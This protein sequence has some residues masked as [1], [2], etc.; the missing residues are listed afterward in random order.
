MT[1]QTRES[2]RMAGWARL[3]AVALLA[4]SV[5]GVAGCTKKKKPA[6]PP[7]P[8]PP[9]KVVI[10][11]PVDVDAVKQQLKA[12]ARV[13]F[14]SSVAPADRTLA[15]GII[16]L[17]DALAKGDSAKLKPMLDRNSQTLLDQLVSSGE[18]AGST[19]GIEQVRIIAVSGTTESHPETSLIGTA[20]QDRDGA[21]LLA[22]HGRHDGNNW[23]FSAAACQGDVKSR[24]SDFDGD[25]IS[26]AGEAPAAEP[27]APAPKAGGRSEPAKAPA[28]PPPAA[29]P[30]GPIKKQT[31]AGPITIPRPSKPSDG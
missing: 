1:N 27:A 22:W 12:D 15:E 4:T 28:T 10:P 5:V 14:P 13:T 17:A 11:D 26:G 8:P 24:A 7:P 25:S 31:P 2:G 29:D 18:W 19:K 20:I 30:N 3:T 9:P 23:T 6:P 16:K 21:Y